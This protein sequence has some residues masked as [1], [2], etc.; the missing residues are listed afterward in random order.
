MISIIQ[1][2][3]SIQQF[4]HYFFKRQY[5]ETDNS[6]NLKKKTI[7]NAIYKLIKQ[8]MDDNGR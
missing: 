3:L 5:V 1:A 2:L 4:N 7:H 6:G 8:M